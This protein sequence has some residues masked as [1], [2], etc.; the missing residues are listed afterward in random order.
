MLIF[1][2]KNLCKNFWK[3]L[4][5]RRRPQNFLTRMVISSNSMGR[6]RLFASK[7]YE[8]LHFLVFLTRR[9]KRAGTNPHLSQKPYE[10]LHLLSFLA[11]AGGKTAVLARQCHSRW[12]SLKIFENSWAS[13]LPKLLCFS[14]QEFLNPSQKHII[15]LWGLRG[16]SKVKRSHISFFSKFYLSKY[17]L[18]LLDQT[19][20]KVLW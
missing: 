6:N 16:V 8:T 5:P 19:F 10:T 13:D 14:F 12:K 3:I 4:E 9:A 7:P 15:T 1:G 18:F 11:C 17:K 20:L 2:Q